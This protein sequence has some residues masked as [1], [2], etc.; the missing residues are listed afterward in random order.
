MRDN[1]YIL[2]KGVIKCTA[3]IYMLKCGMNYLGNRKSLV[4][5]L[6]NESKQN[7]S[8]GCSIQIPV[9]YHSYTLRSIHTMDNLI[10]L[11]E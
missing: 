6:E 8:N 5:T 7:F 9:M 3:M 11:G 4:I 1:Y 10:S 2:Y